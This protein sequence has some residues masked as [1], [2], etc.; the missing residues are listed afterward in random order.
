MVRLIEHWETEFGAGPLGRLLGALALARAGLTQH[1][2][3]ACVG[4]TGSYVAEVLAALDLHLLRIEDRVRFF[5]E[6]FRH[7][8]EARYLLTDAERRTLHRRLAH[9]FMNQNAGERAVVEGAW[10][11][12][13]AGDRDDLLEFLRRPEIVGTFVAADREHELVEHWLHVADI[14]AMAANCVTAAETACASA[15][16]AVAADIAEERAHDAIAL[17]LDMGAVLRRAGRVRDALR[18]LDRAAVLAGE[19]ADDVRLSGAVAAQLAPLLAAAGRLREAEERYRSA[20]ELLRVE[21]GDNHPTVTH[22]L[23]EY[24]GVLAAAGRRGE[25][26]REYRVVLGVVERLGT[27]P[28]AIAPAVNNLA[29]VVHEAGRYEEAEA[30]YRRALDLWTSCGAEVHPDAVAALNNLAA[31]HFD[32]GEHSV[33]RAER[34]RVVE[35]WERALGPDHPMVAAAL[36]NLATQITRDEPDAALPLLERALAIHDAAYPAPTHETAI[37]LYTIGRVHYYAGRLE[38]AEELMRR[39]HELQC[40]VLGAEHVDTA[41][42]LNGLAMVLR[43]RGEDQAAEQ[44][45]RQALEVFERLLGA[46][47]PRVAGAL[48]NIAQLAAKRGE[49]EEARE[50]AVRSLDI[51]D[52]AGGGSARHRDNL[53]SLLAELDSAG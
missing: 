45:L 6:V 18:V 15:I 5:H 20:L 50:L 34:E 30:L 46:R 37:V 26:E 16:E 24:A 28:Q 41:I 10:H 25:A 27:G 36:A 48:T 33:A 21:Y 31:L 35:L 2:V 32:R 4:E 39:A 38:A 43:D 44:L 19:R 29:T 53:R 52:G 8:V 23:G 47:H 42:T 17:A 12:R 51:L 7:S 1:E 11:L 14:D 3:T 40:H 13:G 49:R 22:L 9:V